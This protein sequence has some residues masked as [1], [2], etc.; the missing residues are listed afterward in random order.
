MCNIQLQDLD[1]EQ[2]R[3]WIVGKG[4]KEGFLIYGA[5]TKEFL[6]QHITENN[7]K[8]GLFSLNY[9]GLKTMLNRLGAKTGIQCRPHDFRRGFATALR[10]M[11]VGELD[12][13]QFGRWSSLEMVRRYTKAYTFENAVE[14]YKPI[15]T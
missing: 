11:G 7:P 4:G 14:R 2:N 3:I 6:I 1:L 13:Q 9:E 5:R 12:I 10:R 15:V 8:D